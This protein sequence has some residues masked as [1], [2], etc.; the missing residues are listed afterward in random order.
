MKKILV[1]TDF[2]EHSTA[3]LR[4]A[5]QWSTVE[6]IELVFIH[7]L[8]ISKLPQW[9][10]AYFLQHSENE[11][12]KYKERLEKF[13]SDVYERMGRKQEKY[14]CVVI[15][16]FSADVAILNYCRHRSDIDFICIATRGAGRLKRL[17][18]TNTG[19]IITKSNVPVI[20]I[21]EN[22]QP[23]AF[24]RL[25]YA[26]DFHHYKQELGKV[27]NFARP[28]KMPVEIVHFS[29]PD[30][31]RLDKEIIESGVN[32]EFGYPVRLHIEQ[33]DAV[34]SVVQNLEKQIEVLK[35]SIA[36]M[37]TNQNKSLFQKIFLSSKAEQLSFELKIPLLVF[38]KN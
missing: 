35:P 18:G 24:E 28:L 5:I 21:P 20:A 6:K 22:Y 13:V 34:H 36:I 30:E 3:G 33:N 19:N 23:R 31:A 10:D 17:L 15:E 37:F 8:H 11:K 2:S 29:W 9:T 12:K 14:S 27:V 26:A 25:I 7:V 1:P 16:G 4:F 38:N 32:K